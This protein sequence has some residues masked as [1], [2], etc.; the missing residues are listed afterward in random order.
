MSGDSAGPSRRRDF[1]WTREETILAADVYVN[2][3]GRRMG[4]KTDSEVIELSE[5][6]R[7]APWHPV[8]QRQP[9]FRSIS[10]VYRKLGNLLA[11]DP[12]VTSKGLSHSSRVDREIM[13]EFGSSPEALA[14]A[15][16]AIR[17]E[18]ES[19]TSG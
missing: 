15:A 14:A 1:D 5:L 19:A 10:S 13:E 17:E 7:R 18:I 16:R 12:A 11:N 6:L 9:H 8:E 2:R 4:N 3:L